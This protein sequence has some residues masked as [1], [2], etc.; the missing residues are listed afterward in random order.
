[1]TGVARELACVTFTNPDAETLAGLKSLKVTF[2]GKPKRS[3]YELSDALGLTAEAAAEVALTI[4]DEA[5]NDY[6]ANFT[7]VVEG[8]KLKLRNSKPGGTYIFV[9]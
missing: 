9:R 4:V 7:L 8:T 5:E 2:D 6:S 3:V 1:M